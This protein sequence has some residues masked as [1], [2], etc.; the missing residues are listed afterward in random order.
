MTGHS[1]SRNT[2]VADLLHSAALHLLRSLRKVDSES[3]ITAPRLS[4]L[5]VVVF[6]GPRT[7]GELASA[8]QVKPPT[9]TRL[10]AALETEGLVK[11]EV[12]HND[13]RITRIHATKKG[14]KI[15]MLGRER[16]VSDLAARLAK[17]PASEVRELERA[18]R[19]IASL[20]TSSS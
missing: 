18:A 6:A 15:M 3:G 11:R 14:E 12:D 19:L 17:L 20:A 4:V 5:S 1:S 2:D 8:E 7:L 9:M 10:V 13:R 16:R